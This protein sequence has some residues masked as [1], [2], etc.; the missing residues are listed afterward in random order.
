MGPIDLLPRLESKI[1]QNYAGT[2]LSISEYN[3]GGGNDI[4][5]GIA[6]ADVLGI[7]GR[8]G[9]FSA[10]EWPLASNEAFIGGAFE[11]FRNFDGANGT[12]GDTSVL[13]STSDVASSS[14]YAS[15]DSAHPN[16]VTLVAINKTAQPLPAL[17]QMAHVPAGSTADIYQLTSAA[18]DP[19]YAGRVTVG[20]PSN[21][22]YTMPAYSVSTIRV[23]LPTGNNPPTVATP[24][25]ATPSPVTGTTTSLSVLGADDG[26]EAN[27]TYTWSVTAQPSGAGTPGFSANGTN[28]AKN[29]VAT[30][31]AAGAY[32]FRVTIS[33]GSLSTT[34]DV[35]V[36]VNQT[37]TSISLSP[38]TATVTTG[39]TKQFTATAKDQF[40]A[41]LASQP[42]LAWSLVSGGGSINQSGLYT[43]PGTAGS[44]TIQ[45]VSGGVSGTASVT[46]V[47]PTPPTAP[48]N[49]AASVVSAT[50]INLTW[51][52]NSSDETGFL[53]ERSLDGKTWT[54]IGSVSANVKSY[55]AT[56]LSAVTTYYFRV[57][58]YKGSLYS[59][60]S[61]V[62]SA[63]TKRR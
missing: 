42:A 20:D 57:R 60:Y 58:A 21:F 32:T 49:L 46:I 7:F 52:D 29:S 1:A 44:A 31:S 11:M 41:A 9:V 8:D 5:G 18:S 28:A 16:W 35:S 45:A 15:Y 14:V 61:N 12:F 50:Q 22:N 26:G 37:L 23:V 62:V 56:G 63:R 43:A 38:A 53:I 51:R 27:L 40:G 3:Y 4:S 17:L 25:A 36:T 10:N 24:A 55:S 33:D 13:A 19:R 59:A 6:E 47:A 2:K 54:Q 34:S 48:S 30:F 39:T